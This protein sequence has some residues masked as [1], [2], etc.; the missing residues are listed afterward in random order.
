MSEHDPL[1]DALRELPRQRAS[2]AFTAR[3]LERAQA[4]PPRL[5]PRRWRWAATAAL[6]ALAATVWQ[7]GAAHHGRSLER[8]AQLLLAERR[9]L[10]GELA[11]LRGLARAEPALHVAGGADFEVVVGL[12]PWLAV[13]QEI[14]R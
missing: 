5:T 9:Q 11:R 12:A 7:L 10:Q 14:E 2:Q 13:R 8:Q 4:P 1:R 6:A 3:L